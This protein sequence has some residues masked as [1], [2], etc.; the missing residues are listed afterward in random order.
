MKKM[1]LVFVGALLLL[2]CLAAAGGAETFTVTNDSDEK[3][4]SGSL[5]WA[6]NQANNTSSEQEHVINVSANVKLISVGSPL[7]LESNVALNGNGVTLQGRGSNIFDLKSGAVK[8]DCVTFTGGNA[9]NEN[10]GAVNIS[11]TASAQF[12]NCTFFGNSADGSG[13]AVYANG[14]GTSTFTHCTFAGNSAQ[15]GG[16]VAVKK[17]TVRFTACV[18]T[19]NQNKAKVSDDVSVDAQGVISN[20]SSYNVIGSTA[21]ENN[22]PSSLHNVMGQ[23]ASKVFALNP[24]A[25]E[26][27]DGVQVLRLSAVSA[28]IDR[29]PTAQGSTPSPDT[30]E[31]GLARPQLLGYDAGA[32]EAEPVPVE[33]IQLEGLSYI[34]LNMSEDY[35][36]TAT[37]VDA[38]RNRNYPEGIEW[39]VSDPSVISVDKGVVKALAVGTST[40]F[41]TLHGWNANKQEI[42]V[43]PSM[44]QIHVGED[45]LPTPT[46]SI[47]VIPDQSVQAGQTKTYK[48]T[49]TV[50][51]YK[52]KTALPYALHVSSPSYE[53]GT[54]EV[55]G[56]Q[57]VLTGVAAGS[58]DISVT[59]TATNKVGTGTSAAQ[60][61]KL[62]VSQGSS[63]NKG[64]GGCY[65]GV[66]SMAL[67]ALTGLMLTKKRGK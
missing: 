7:T 15:H 52:Y 55:S 60:Q 34:Q 26:T 66:D 39:S 57:I 30:D 51:L 48:P 46:L 40:L 63:S 24:L 18:I 3:S 44:L 21:A 29:V 64:S 27:V 65:A 67:L 20:E 58:A 56:D 36:V 61:F 45:P 50:W 43:G 2:S 19:G 4:A 11:N 41:A 5:R 53:A 33:S 13:G 23:T 54:A 22:F 62:T 37:P 9:A 16:G 35:T 12:T 49:V 10:G 31:R 38:S 25:L 6:V 59:A 1:T 28:A 8:F 32:F 42:T 14:S 17:G 47:D